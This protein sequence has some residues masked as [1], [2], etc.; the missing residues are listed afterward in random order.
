MV[1]VLVASIQMDD[2]TWT[3]EKPI[4]IGWYW[5]KPY[6][7]WDKNLIEVSIYKNRLMALGWSIT[8]MNGY[9]AGPIPEPKEEII[10]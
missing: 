1:V 8:Y 2:L 3:K 7:K 6:Q 5:Y 10:K 9:W 4:K